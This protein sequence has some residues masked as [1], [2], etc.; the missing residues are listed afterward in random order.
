MVREAIEK[1]YVGKCTVSEL[2]ANTDPLT[3][4]TNSV[5][6]IVLKDQPCRLSFKTV[7]KVIEGVTAAQL[8]QE[9]KLFIAPELTIKPGSLITVTQNSVTKD[10]KNSGEPA[11]YSSHQEIVLEL[12]KGWS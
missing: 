6:V 7:Y 12:F 5:P 10:Y 8:A 3:K 11:W 1:L 2:H 4:I 9:V